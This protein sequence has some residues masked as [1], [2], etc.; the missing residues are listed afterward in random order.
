MWSFEI[1]NINRRSICL[2]LV[3]TVSCCCCWCE[4]CLWSSYWWC[5]L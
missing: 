1:F 3:D 4:C 5:S 2:C